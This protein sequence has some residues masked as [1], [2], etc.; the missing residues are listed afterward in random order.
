MKR[1][2]KMKRV[3]AVLLACCM[4]VGGRLPVTAENNTDV[5]SYEVE[6][7]LLGD[8][9]TKVSNLPS[10]DN[11]LMFITLAEDTNFRWNANDSAGQNS[12]IHL[13]DY[14]GKNCYFRFHAL[15]DGY[16]G[17]KCVDEAASENDGDET[18]RYV[19][20]DGKSTDSGAKLHLFEDDDDEV[21]D[22][23]PHRWFAFYYV[24]TDEYGNKY[25]YIQNKKSGLWV[26]YEDS[27]N[28]GPTVGDKLIQTTEA[29]RKL[30][31]ITNGVVP[32]SGNEYEE[33]IAFKEGSATVRDEG[34]FIEIFQEGT[35]N[36]I[37]RAW[38]TTIDGTF[39]HLYEMGTSSKWLIKWDEA[40]S[41]YK[42]YAVKRSVADIDLHMDLNQPI[43]TTPSLNEIITDQVWDLA[44][45][46]STMIHLWGDD[47][48]AYNK[49]TNK[50]WRF[51]KQSDGT[52]KIQ[53]ARTGQYVEGIPDIDT[54]HVYKLYTSAGGTKFEIYPIAG[55]DTDV[56]FNYATDW[57][58]DIPNDVLL[59]T[60]NIPGSHD[61]GTAAIVEDFTA[62]YSITQ[63]QKYYYGEQL[64]AGIRAFDVRCDAK[65]DTA[66]LSEVNIVH[67][68]SVWKCF[69]RDGSDLKLQDILDD[70]VRFLKNHPSETIVMMVKPDAGSVEGLAHALN[71]F[72]TDEDTK[73][74]VYDK[75][76]IPSMGEARGKIVFIWRFDAGSYYSSLGFGLNLSNWDDFSYKDFTG[77]VKIY[78]Q[79]NIT[80]NV[81]DA[82]NVDADDKKIYIEDAIRESI[83]VP[84]AEPVDQDAW[85]FNYTSCASGLPHQLT[86]E[87]NPWLYEDC[88]NNGD[89]YID[90]RRLGIVMLNYVDNPMAKLI[91]ET[92]NENTDYYVP[93]VTAPTSVT[94]THGDPLEEAVLS[95]GTGNGTW[96]FEDGSYIPSQSDYD[97]HEKYT[98]IF[99]PADSRY[100][101]V[102]AEV[103]ITN[104]LPKA[105]NAEVD[106]KEMTY[107][108]PI[109]ELTYSI[110][111]SQFVGCE[112]T[113]LISTELEIESPE[114]TTSGNLKA[115]T[116]TIKA[117]AHSV[118][119]DVTFTTGTLKVK[120]KTLGIEWSDTSNL[121]YTGSPVNVTATITG[122]L[123]GD[124][125][126]ASVTGGNATEPS[127]DGDPD[128]TPNTYTAT[129][130]LSGADSG[131]YCLPED[132]DSMD[133]YIRRNDPDDYSFPTKAVL[134]YGQTLSEA[135]LI[136]ASGEG[137]FVFVSVDES[138]HW[139]N[140]ND[141]K[142]AA[143]DY[144]YRMLY[145][146][147]DSDIEHGVLSTQQIQVVVSK[148]P[149]TVRAEAKTKTYGDVTPALTYTFDETQLVEGD[150]R[151]SLGLTLSAGNG[152]NQF[153]NAGKYW[154]KK[155]S[156]CTSANYDVTVIPSYLT[157]SK[158]EA[159]ITWNG[160]V[161]YTYNGNPV[162]VTATVSNVTGGD[163]CEVKVIGGKRTDAGSYKAVA[164]SLSNGNY[165]FKSEEA[166]RIFAYEI[167]KADPTVTFP[168]AA[169]ITYGEELDE[170]V[171]TGES[172][173]V[174]GEFELEEPGRL[175]TVA[176]SG[177]RYN[178]SFVPK[179]T[180]NY[181]TIT[182]AEGLAVTVHPKTVTVYADRKTKIYGQKTPALTW[183]LN[184]S[185]LVGADSADEFDFTLTA[186]EGEN[187]NCDVG[188]YPI[189]FTATTR[190]NSNYAIEF[191]KGVLIVDPRMA[192]IQWNPHYNIVVG[193][194]GPSAK[195]TNLV[196][197]DDCT[198]V[199]ECD[200]TD[201]PSWTTGSET[202]KD[203]KIFNA[204]VAGLA[205]AD[206][207]NYTL[208]EDDM[209]I[210]YLVRRQDSDDFYMPKEAIVT[211]GKKLSDARLILACG[212]GTFTFVD[213]SSLHKD[214]GDTVPDAGE[215][216]YTIKF[217]PTD[218][219]KKPEYAQITVLVRKKNVKVTALT[220]EKTY[221]DTTE[222]D[223]EL[224]ESQ[225]AF[226]D[227]KEDLKL[228]LTAVSQSGEDGD[229]VNSP[230]GAYEIG[231]K[232]CG[233]ENYN[234][235]V[236]SAWL[237]IS[238]KAVSVVWPGGSNYSY[239][240]SPVNVIAKA[241]GVLEGEQCD[242]K[243]A[244]GNRVEI[245][246]YYAYAY[247][248]SNSNYFLPKDYSMRIKEY[249]ILEASGNGDGANTDN[250]GS[251]DPNN[252]DS[253]KPDNG[254]GTGTNNGSGTGTNNGSGADTCDGNV[255]NDG[256]AD[257]PNTADPTN[258][259]FVLLMMLFAVLS[260]AT[261]MMMMRR[262]RRM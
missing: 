52:Y 200:G 180:K 50:L 42:I 16:Y 32:K 94:L 170:V 241:Q 234:V 208:P 236:E 207:Y 174:P 254:S 184:E 237:Y 14:S 246:T 68:G 158:K 17:I 177:S 204:E 148:K 121:V 262:K 146:P 193:G 159:E 182:A 130:V 231:L 122:V 88:M 186:G 255:T 101:S 224:D 83:G 211:Y 113:G 192:E 188:G 161:E 218:T 220:S 217:T 251:T 138:D 163:P 227:T 156:A 260:G 129:A 91:Y 176:D 222:L 244:N 71:S 232:E 230:V 152:D 164:V 157:V 34:A 250:G 167:K 19:D 56:N 134:T 118:C 13:D 48:T 44:D 248:L 47:T 120:P 45:E 33:M 24:K 74:Y 28:D 147:V 92:N 245:G 107:G 179:D 212:D 249:T 169:S 117:T 53:N 63:C 38:D 82:F 43:E 144:S 85:I 31:I 143:G 109:P 127:W 102:T 69:D 205:G 136:G 225:L 187:Q 133:Y 165:V 35:I 252:G 253:T 150:T 10:G 228:T 57:M 2:R 7:E 256:K 257:A 114:Y 90:Y 62:G 235:T 29:N 93:K 247:G 27:E 202:L 233:N 54:A 8:S 189:S 139:T 21:N 105:I 203:L 166:N 67:G 103:Q 26:G 238:P 137:E 168:T 55:T 30:W 116:Y 108:D 135:T 155:S 98:M 11:D 153:C 76:D 97:N 140:I 213:D 151:E 183:H 37:N 209:T 131:N 201:T 206:C 64:N 36:T 20:I 142:P 25:Y 178:I 191:K 81:Q 175:L 22:K 173:S 219:N 95:G 59:S 66:S 99:T 181:N 79:D 89:G 61:T 100:K 261:S 75:S 197:G 41:A 77:T 198:V 216:T 226:D 199:V 115:G 1:L 162:D 5:D 9:E 214:I 23:N 141:T 154:I 3:V 240:G 39:L 46:T 104:Y 221:G 6:Q 160:S 65:S 60:V 229:R 172:S 223:F 106:D 258:M 243:V 110:D 125:C 194:S 119:Y 18:G 40:H 49:H 15:S 242:V 239:T 210:Q 78:D 132:E 87:I 70:S 171:F 124:D 73:D 215:Y 123:S 195:V 196:D 126:V 259:T 80:V 4:C 145:K 12:V 149:I 185:E 51:I 96:S 86:E 58:A 190:Q 84:W 112:N 111:E 128:H 72:V